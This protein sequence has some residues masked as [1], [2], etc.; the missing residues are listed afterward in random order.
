METQKTGKRF[1]PTHSRIE[2]EM[3]TEGVAKGLSAP[4]GATVSNGGVNISVFAR[5]ATL[6][7][8]TALVSIS[9]QSCRAMSP[10]IPLRVLP[11]QSTAAR[12]SKAG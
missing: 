11:L 3:S 4:L 12:A 9:R 8:L 5:D 7:E 1:S 2:V 10:A 6:V